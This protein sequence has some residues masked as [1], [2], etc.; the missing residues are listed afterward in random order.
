MS[1]VRKP[2]AFSR[3]LISHDT[4]MLLL[5]AEGRRLNALL[6]F[7]LCH[8]KLLYPVYRMLSSVYG[9]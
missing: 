5:S 1:N 3:Q 7:A 8:L 4:A 2:S 9:L 6:P